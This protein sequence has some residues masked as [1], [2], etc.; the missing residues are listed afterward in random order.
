MIESTEFTAQSE[1]RIP[2]HPFTT[3]FFITASVLVVASTFYK[4]PQ[5]SL[6][7]IAI[8]GVGI[9]VYFLWRQ[10]NRP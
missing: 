9:P 3:L 5:N 10:K 8:A 2:G 1:Y 4:Y 7:G 6:I